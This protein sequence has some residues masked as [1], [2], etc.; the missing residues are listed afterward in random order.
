M[1]K[2][3]KETVQASS[4]KHHTKAPCAQAFNICGKAGKKKRSWWNG[5]RPSAP[6][7]EAE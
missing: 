6:A 2:G 1:A 4:V 7:P 3:K 5:H